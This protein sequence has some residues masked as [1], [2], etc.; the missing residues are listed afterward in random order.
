MTLPFIDARFQEGN[1]RPAAQGDTKALVIGPCSGGTKENTIYTVSKATGIGD[2]IGQGNAQL[3]ASLLIANAPS[4]FGQV[5]VIVANASVAAS[6]SYVTTASPAIT[7]SGTPYASYDLI[8]TITKAG[9]PG[10]ARFVY[11]LDGGENYAAERVVPA[12]GTFAIANT[13]L[14]A[15]F[16]TSSHAVDNT[17]RS[18]IYGPSMN[19]A[20]LAPC[21]NTLSSSNANYTLIL[22]ADDAEVPTNAAALFSTLDTA[23]NVLDNSQYK[24]TQGVLPVGGQ[25]FLNNRAYANFPGSVPSESVLTAITGSVTSNR[26]FI[27]C[28]AERANTVIPDPQ[29]GYAAPRLPFAWA[30]AAAAHGVGTD[31]SKNPLEDTM[32]FV[33]KVSYDEQNPGGHA[34][35]VDEKIIAPRTWPGSPGIMI[36]Q[37]HLKTEPDS[38]YRLWPHSRVASIAARTAVVALRPYIGKRLRTLAAGN[39]DPRDAASINAVVTRALVANLGTPTNGQGQQGHVQSDENGIPKIAFVTNEQNDFL[40]TGQIQG[41]VVMVPYGYVDSIVIDIAFNTSINA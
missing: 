39:L 40:A 27:A 35:Y 34:G 12:G 6:S 1:A 36:N 26:K 17:M 25:T 20:D 14:T 23:L 31:V 13:G 28:V 22:I 32:P 8:V 4:G 38:T 18:Y 37:S 19:A 21:L 16:V 5:D 41:Q 30:F 24:F 9:L 3:A 10:T 2:S 33:T 15:N 11:S 7:H 29:P